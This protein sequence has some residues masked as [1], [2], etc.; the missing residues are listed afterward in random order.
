MAASGHR[1]FHRHRATV[2]DDPF[3]SY[4]S[5]S[6]F[7]VGMIHGIGAETPTQ[8]LIFVTAAGAGGRASG[9]LLLGIFIVGLLSSNTVIALAGTFGFLGASSNFKLYVAVSVTTALFSLV[10][11]T[12][13]LY[14][15]ATAL[16]AIFGG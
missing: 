3:V 5:K 6:A 10:I 13:F 16:P 15:D 1:H 7:G 14:G 2:P 12:L 4:G 9:L 8:I 11:G